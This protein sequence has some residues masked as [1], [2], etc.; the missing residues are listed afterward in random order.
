MGE[1]RESRLWEEHR[2]ER[3]K[4]TVWECRPVARAVKLPSLAAPS[5][6]VEFNEFFFFFFNVREPCPIRMKSI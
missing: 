5:V 6:R 3:K 1:E 4:N 2:E